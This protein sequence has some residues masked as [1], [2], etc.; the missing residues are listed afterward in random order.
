MSNRERL[1]TFNERATLLLLREEAHR[2]Q[3][4]ERIATLRATLM[5]EGCTLSADV[6]IALQERLR[7]LERELDAL[8]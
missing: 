4:R 1:L 7:N 8:R 2:N 6:Y 5:Q 3:L